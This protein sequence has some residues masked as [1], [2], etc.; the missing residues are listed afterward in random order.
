MLARWAR[1]RDVHL[2]LRGETD[3]GRHKRKGRSERPGATT[4]AMLAMDP[5]QRP[6]NL[7]TAGPRPP[8]TY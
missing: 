4:E 7:L 2:V 3:R 1:R 5:A 8:L 6:A